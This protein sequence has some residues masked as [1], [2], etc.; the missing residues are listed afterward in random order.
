[1]KVTIEDADLR[2]KVVDYLA[3]TGIEV[4]EDTPVSIT[5]PGAGN[6]PQ[7]CASGSGKMTAGGKFAPGYDAKLKSSLYAIIRGKPDDISEELKEHGPMYR[8]LAEWT[9]ELAQE[10]LQAFGWPDPAPPKPKKE[11]VKKEDGEDGADSN[12]EGE[13]RKGRRRKKDEEAGADANAENQE[14]T[15]TV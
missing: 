12:G 1:M 8:P 6:T 3:L 5:L 14:E 7:K 9:P 11:K 15:A 2:Q 10:T 4:G 13:T